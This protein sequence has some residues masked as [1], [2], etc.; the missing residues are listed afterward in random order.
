MHKSDSR[1]SRWLW[2]ATGFVALLN[3]CATYEYV[4][5]EPVEFARTIGREDVAIE[6]EPLT[7]RFTDLKSRLG[8]KVVNPNDEP[9]TLV[10]EKSYVVDPA[11]QS[12]PM[13][14]GTIAPDSFVAF[15]IPPAARMYDAGPRFGVGVGFGSYSDGGF[16]GGSVGHTFY[17]DGG[18]YPASYEVVNVWQW[19]EGRVTLRLMVERTG[20]MIEHEFVFLR[21]KVEE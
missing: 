14:G 10:G 5:V 12:Y 2:L 20:Q 16:Y 19:K 21:R 11:G 13:R 15:T 17:D 3:G 8:V 18:W 6:R 4:L 7:Y 9:V 1:K